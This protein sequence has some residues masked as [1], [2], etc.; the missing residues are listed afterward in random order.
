MI[1]P[2]REKQ[3]SGEVEDVGERRERV[4]LVQELGQHV[5]GDVAGGERRDPESDEEPRHPVGRPVADDPDDDRRRRAQAEQ[6]PQVHVVLGQQEDGHHQR[7][8]DAQIDPGAI[9]RRPAA[10]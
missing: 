10:S 6:A 1:N 9:E 5:V 2:G 3:V 4:G 7:H 8:V